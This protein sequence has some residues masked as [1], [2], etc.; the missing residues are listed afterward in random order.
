MPGDGLA[1]I[2]VLGRGAEPAEFSA[3]MG[4]VR[5]AFETEGIRVAALRL[6]AAAVVSFGRGDYDAIIARG[7][8][9]PDS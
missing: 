9:A 5:T 4:R 8:G 3:R 1:E 2:F 7:R 6:E